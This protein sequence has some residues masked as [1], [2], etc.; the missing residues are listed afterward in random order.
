MN[1]LKLLPKALKYSSVIGF[2]TIFGY[3]SFKAVEKYLAKP[4]SS[5][6]SYTFGD[7]GTG[8]IGYYLI[9]KKWGIEFDNNCFAEFP[10]ITICLDEFGILAD[11]ESGPLKNNCSN[12]NL[13]ARP[14]EFYEA[15]MFCLKDNILLEKPTATEET[16]FGNLFDTHEE[17]DVAKYSSIKEFLEAVKIKI[18]EILYEF[19][20]GSYINLDQ[21]NMAFEGGRDLL[22]AYWLTEL[23]Y[24]YGFCYTFDPRLVMKE[25]VQVIQEFISGTTLL[26]MK[27]NF[28]V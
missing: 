7:D 21:D 6:V 1:N 2:L 4:I 17:E 8:H 15:L 25:K 27:L 26:S 18:D 24:Q 10:A 22:R 19:H 12:G 9:F 14:K 11:G 5:S 3:W 16:L 23:H 13:K 20:F 28:N